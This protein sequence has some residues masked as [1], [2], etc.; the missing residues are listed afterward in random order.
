MKNM[1]HCL[2]IIIF[3]MIPQQTVQHSAMATFNNSSPNRASVKSLMWMFLKFC[4][5]CLEIVILW[6]DKFSWGPYE[7]A[8]IAVHQRLLWRPRRTRGAAVHEGAA[9]NKVVYCYCKDWVFCTGGNRCNKGHY[10]PAET[11]N[12]WPTRINAGAC[13]FLELILLCHFRL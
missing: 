9:K 3:G 1:G 2:Y 8:Y 5:N 4:K 11:T 10:W 12:E 6:P 7:K 13:A